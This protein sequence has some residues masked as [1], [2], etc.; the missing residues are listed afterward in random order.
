MLCAYFFLVCVIGCVLTCVCEYVS[1]K[2]S[3][4]L[5]CELSVSMNVRKL[6]GVMA[7]I[8]NN[9]RKLNINI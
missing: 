4:C 1:V 5:K 7:C 8:K 3:E 2:G 9:N 6:T